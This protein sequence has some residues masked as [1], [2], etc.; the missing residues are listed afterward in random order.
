MSNAVK[1]IGTYFHKRSIAF[2]YDYI[3]LA[4]S[5]CPSNFEDKDKGI[6]KGHI[7]L[8]ISNNYFIPTYSSKDII[9]YDLTIRKWIDNPNDEQRKLMNEFLLFYDKV[10]GKSQSGGKCGKITKQGKKCQRSK[11]CGIHN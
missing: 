11:N 7:Y 5:L 2:K 3:V 8:Y 10:F 6:I 4:S 1:F 9:L